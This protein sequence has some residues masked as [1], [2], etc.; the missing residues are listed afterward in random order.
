MQRVGA[1]REALAE[2]LV[3][4]HG[5]AVVAVGANAGGNAREVIVQRGL[6]GD[7]IDRAARRAAAREAGAGALGD[8]DL[9]DGEALARGHAGVAQAVHEHVGARFLASDDVAVA[10]GI[11]VLARA[12]GDA[13]LCRQDLLQIGQARVVNRCLGHHRDGLRRFRQRA[14][15]ARVGRGFGLVGRADFGVRV[16]VDGLLLHR[17]GGQGGDGRGALGHGAQGQ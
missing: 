16:R 8:F 17:H 5:H 13:G 2:A 6:L 11:A 15:M 10:E 3:R 4:V 12:Q 14:G 1:Q 7:G 9:L